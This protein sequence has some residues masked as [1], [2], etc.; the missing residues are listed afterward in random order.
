MRQIWPQMLN[1]SLTLFVTVAIFPGV[2]S[3]V[4]AWPAASGE[5]TVLK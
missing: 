4:A 1:A 5:T 3:R 2:A